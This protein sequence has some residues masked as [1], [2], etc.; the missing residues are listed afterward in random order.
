MPHLPQSP[1]LYL[2]DP[3]F[4][5]TEHLADLTQG[6]LPHAAAETEPEPDHG[7]FSQGEGWKNLLEGLPQIQL[8][9]GVFNRLPQGI[10]T[11]SGFDGLS[12]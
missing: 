3:F 10:G 12:V 6:M 8:I 9:I 4:C 11:T 5:S 7:F 1:H 2:S